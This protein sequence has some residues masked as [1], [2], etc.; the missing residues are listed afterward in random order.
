MLDKHEKT[1]SPLDLAE[2]LTPG[3]PVMHLI[4]NNL[5]NARIALGRAA[6]TKALCCRRLDREAEAC[7]NIDIERRLGVDLR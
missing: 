6:S 5:P 4:R 1:R 3:A 2:R 7:R